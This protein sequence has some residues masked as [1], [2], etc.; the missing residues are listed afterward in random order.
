VAPGPQPEIDQSLAI[1]TDIVWNSTGD[2]G[3]VA[4]MGSELVGLI[5]DAGDVLHRIP[6]GGGPSGLALDQARGALYVVNRFDNTISVVDLSTLAEA[7]VVD[8][9]KSG[10]DPTPEDVKLGRRFHYDAQLTSAHG[11][12]ACASCHVFANFDALAWDLG[13]PK[14]DFIETTDPEFPPGMIDP[15]L[16]GFHPMKGP[17]MTQ[18][19]RGLATVPPFHWRG[20][21]IGF[22]D[23]NQAF[24][25]LLGN[26][27]ELTAPEM[28][29]Y[30]AFIMSIHYPPNPNQNLDRSFPDAPPGQPSAQ[31]GFVTYMNDAH[32][33]GLTCNQC[34]DI[35]SGGSIGQIINDQALQEDQDMLIPQLRNM[36]EKVGFKDSAVTDNKLGYGYLHDGV[37]DNLFSFLGLPVFQFVDD[38]QRRDMEAFLLAFDTGTAPIVGSQVTV[39]GTNKNDAEILALLSLMH[40]RASGPDCDLIA[41]GLVGG[42]QRGYAMNF[43]GEFQSDRNWEDPLTLDELRSLATDGGELTFTCVPVGSGIRAGIDRD[44]D[45]AYDRLE[46]DAG[47]DPADPTSTP[48]LVAVE[49]GSSRELRFAGA[50]PNPFLG[51]TQLRFTLPSPGHVRLT[52]YDPRGRE[53]RVLADGPLPPQASMPSPSTGGTARGGVWQPGSTSPG[54][55][56]AG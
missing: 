35:G 49:T 5:G 51:R 24:M 42:L 47:T 20:D 10:F 7:A 22:D 54:W 1:P 55:M 32:A 27:R 25:S 8:I 39:S 30:K 45:E 50:A 13:D 21:R 34:H 3:Y 11:D 4:A 38:D 44:R 43:I 41:K 33:G 46:L 12:V 48:D 18:S 15:L 26:D 36:Y 37:V 19:L 14:G 31:R 2:S 52:L 23:F 6:V 9:G 29:Q 56:S 40:I 16:E 53:V 28:A 17:M